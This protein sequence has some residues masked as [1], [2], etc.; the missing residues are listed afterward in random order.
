[1]KVKV[2]GKL[3]LS[4]LCSD[5][6][7]SC[8]WASPHGKIPWYPLNWRLGGSQSWSGCFEKI[9][10]PWWGSN[11]SSDIQPAGWALYRPHYP[12]SWYI[13]FWNSP[14]P[15]VRMLLCRT[16]KWC[17]GYHKMTS[18]LRTTQIAWICVTKTFFQTSCFPTFIIL[19][20]VT[21]KHLV[22]KC[23]SY[24][25]SLS[26]QG[27]VTYLPLTTPPRRH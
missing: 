12:N 21:C 20:P 16:D 4:M 17:L 2:K 13:T 3:S 10:C 11:D 8:P 7:A 14:V 1:M 24:Y 23:L 22:L 27:I 25:C 6:S 18:W 5:W 9:F 26:S 19:V 15:K